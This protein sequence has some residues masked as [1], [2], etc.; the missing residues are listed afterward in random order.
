MKRILGIFRK[1][2]RHL[3]PQALLFWAVL[4]IPAAMHHLVNW[5]SADRMALLLQPLACWLLVVSVIHGETLVGHQQYWLTRPYSRKHL[6]AAKCPV[7]GGLRQPAAVC[8]PVRYSRERR[9]LAAGLA[10]R[11]A[12]ETGLLYDTLRPSGRG[13]GRCHAKPGTGAAGGHPDGRDALGWR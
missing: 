6:M 10:L 8:L 1:D 7:S 9:L 5:L 12:L 4:G 13:G 11:A 3:W 2:V